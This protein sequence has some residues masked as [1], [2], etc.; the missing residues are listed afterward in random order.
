[1]RL[2]S[3]K[4]SSLTSALLLAAAALTGTAAAPTVA[5]SPVQV[6]GAWHCGNDACTWATV[7]NMT[8]FDT[9]NHWL[10]DRGDGHPSVNLA[11]LSFV[12]PLKLL[13]GTTDSG[14]VNG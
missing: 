10:I 13:N 4:L 8:D 12:N 3:G 6:Y 14:D 9:D 1:M 7:R 2:R 11:V 5:S